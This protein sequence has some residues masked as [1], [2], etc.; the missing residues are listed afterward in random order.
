VEYPDDISCF[1]DHDVQDESQTEL[2]L[3]IVGDDEP[4]KMEESQISETDKTTRQVFAEIEPISPYS[5]FRGQSDDDVK[6][7]EFDVDEFLS[8][9]NNDFACPSS[10]DS[11]PVSPSNPTIIEIDSSFKMQNTTAESS[12][13]GKPTNDGY[14]MIQEGDFI[15]DEFLLSSCA[16]NNELN[17]ACDITDVDDPFSDLFPSL[18]SV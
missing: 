15:D 13:V 18:L 8:N 6:C 1:D 4:V 12:V 9:E 2:F 16:V 7:E 10:P 17:N 11:E 5:Q 3:D 14:R